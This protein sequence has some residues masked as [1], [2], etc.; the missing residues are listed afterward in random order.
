MKI[1]FVK[2]PYGFHVTPKCQHLYDRLSELWSKAATGEWSIEDEEEY[3]KC[4]VQ[5]IIGMLAAEK[6]TCK[7]KLHPWSPKFSK[8][9]ETK[10][11]WKILL[12]LKRH[13]IRPDLKVLSWGESLGITEVSTLQMTFI[14]SKLHEA[15]K[16]LREIKKEAVKLREEHLRELLQITQEAANDKNQEK[17][18]RILIRAHEKK[19][20]YRKIQHIL[21][22]KQRSGLSHVL[23]P[24]D[25]N[26]EDYPYK[27][28]EVKS[29]R[30]IHEHNALQRYL[31]ERNKQ[32]FGQA[33][34]TPFTVPPLNKIDWGVNNQY[35]ETLIQG[36]IHE[37]LLSENKFATSVLKFIAE[38]KQLLEIDLYISPEEIAKGFRSWKETT[39]TSP[40]A[41]HLG[42]RQIPAIPTDDKELEKVRIQILQVQTNII[43]IPLQTGFSP[44]RW[45]TIINAMLEKIQGR[46]LLH[47]LCVIHILE[48]DYNLVLKTIFGR[49]LMKNCEK[50][51]TLGNIQDGFRKGRSTTRTLLHNEIINDYNKWLRIDNYIGMTDIS[52]CFERI[53]PPIIGLLNRR[54]GC[55]KTATQ[56]HAQTLYQAKYF[57]KTHSGISDMFYLNA[58]TPVYGNGQGAGDSPS[59]WSQESAMLL[60]MYEEHVHGASMSLRTGQTIARLPMAA[61]ADDINLLGNNDNN[62]KTRKDL[63]QEVQTAFTTW[64]RLLHATGHFMEL[65]KCVSYLSLWEFQEDGYAYTMM[66]EEHKQEIFVTD[67]LGNTQ[68]IQ[69][70]P[71]NK[72][73]KLLGVMKCPMGDQQD[74]IKRLQI[75]SDNLASRLNSNHLTR[76]E[77]RLAYEAFYLPAMRYSLNITSINQTDIETIQAKA[78]AAFLSTQGF[79]RHMPC[80]V[81]F[82]PRI[83]QGVGMRHLYDIQGSDSTQLL[84]QELN[85]DNSQTQHMLIALLDA[86]QLEAGIGE[87]I[88]EDC[89]PLNNV[90]WGWVHQIR[91]FLNH[92]NGKV[93][94]GRR[95]LKR[96]RTHDTYLMD[97]PYLATIS[98]KERIY[99]NRCRIYLQVATMSDIATATGFQ[100][101]RSWYEP[102]TD[103]PAISKLTWPCQNSPCKEAWNSW[104]KFLRSF[105]RPN[106]K[107]TQ[108]L[109]S[110]LEHNPDRVHQAYIA[111]QGD[112]I[113]VHQSNGSFHGHPLLRK[114]R[115][116]M[117]FHGSSTTIADSPAISAVLV[118]IIGQYDDTIRTSNAATNSIPAA[119]NR[120]NKP[121]FETAPSHLTYLAGKIQLLR[122]VKEINMVITEV[123]KIIIA[124]DGGH[125]PSSGTSSF[126][127]AM[128]INDVVI[129]KG[130]G[131]VQVAPAMAESFRAEGYGLASACL[132]ARNFI[133]KFGINPQQHHWKIVIDSKSLIQRIT[134]YGF[135]INI[136]RW[137][138]RPDE[139][140]CKVAYKLLKKIPAT[141]V[142]VKSHQEV[143]KKCRDHH[144]DITLNHIADN[145]ATLQRNSM[146]VPSCHVNN[147]SA[148]QLW[149]D[150]VAITRESQ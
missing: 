6:K 79:N 128:A 29:W 4:D 33:H 99:I 104:K 13:H 149:I 144:M 131:P 103:K 62:N 137:N 34:G 78:T 22:P 23:V 150:N 136:P 117:V 3:N 37:A 109:G 110:W 51:G 87:S 126:G 97:S 73:Q 84:L 48:A 111:E 9:V 15:Q 81:V 31:Q 127:W 147:I 132:F 63:I 90:E 114:Q 30:M 119:K 18:L 93:I 88:L 60:K 100:I 85:Q 92:I 53:L 121:W 11:F 112:M 57:L 72:S 14:N 54:N 80:E 36:E 102:H 2:Q 45:Q 39:S 10:N 141:I 94:L 95:K 83:Y 135:H 44:V 125:D 19:Y 77:A 5:H 140:I 91:D 69:Q 96:Y 123:S 55:P 67:S 58:Q 116:H 46:P 16:T 71:T 74:E 21:K 7:M 82:A 120:K 107:L 148:A 32:H 124:S 129:A 42:L 70:L 52:G 86:M 17:Q 40:S 118:N 43:N 59:Q 143:N 76:V 47:K 139:D 66:P 27:P 38:Q 142:H 20:H 61:F 65:G 35:A 8:A 113:W 106:G 41:C 24:E 134:R 25:M 89:R 146:P 64:D 12:T 130:R 1:W 49:R 108:P 98:R 56:M 115:R 75:K 138:L 101:H 122:L 145:K 68:K 26:P 28:D 133:H 50:H 105:E